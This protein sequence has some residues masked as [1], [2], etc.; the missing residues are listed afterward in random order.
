MNKTLLLILTILLTSTTAL[1]SSKVTSH[2]SPLESELLDSFTS[3]SDDCNM[4][5][6]EWRGQPLTNEHLSIMQDTCSLVIGNFYK[7]VKDKGFPAKN[8]S[9]LDYKIS[10]LPITDSYRSLNDNKYRFVNRPK[11]CGKDNERCDD[12]EET[13]FLFGWTDHTIKRMFLRN[14]LDINKDNERAAFQ[15]IFAH[16]LFHVLSKTSGSF[17]QHRSFLIEEKLAHRFTK[18][19]GLGDI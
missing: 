10:A 7:F 8:K 11:F 12:N 4:T 18:E 2:P 6:D 17:E 3:L 14:D 1:S 16:E 9:I 13:W 15:V 19:I 5:I